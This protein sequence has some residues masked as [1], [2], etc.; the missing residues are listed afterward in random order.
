MVLLNRQKIFGFL[1]AVS[2]LLV[3]F[4]RTRMNYDF[5]IV[6]GGHRLGLISWLTIA[7]IIGGGYIDF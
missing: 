3:F 2:L 1:M 6:V 4:L 7:L 5:S